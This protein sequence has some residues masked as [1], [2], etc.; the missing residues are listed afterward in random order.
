MPVSNPQKDQLGEPPGP[1]INNIVNL[2]HFSI[3]RAI[4]DPK[5]SLDRRN[6]KTKNFTTGV[7]PYGDS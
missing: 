1:K 2:S 3:T 4:L 7:N 5:V 6:Y